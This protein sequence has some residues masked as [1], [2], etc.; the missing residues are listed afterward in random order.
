MEA[1]LT[2]KVIYDTGKRQCLIENISDKVNLEVG[3]I[4]ETSGFGG[5]Y[6]KGILI[7]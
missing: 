7:E 1:M 2:L 6:P 5:I 4:V 3:D